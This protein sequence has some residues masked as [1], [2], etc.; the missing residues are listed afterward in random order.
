MKPNMIKNAQDLL[1]DMQKNFDEIK[2]LSRTQS[3]AFENFLQST[4]DSGMLDTKT[5]ALIG[6][7]LA[8]LKQCKWCITYYVKTALDNKATKEQILEAGWLAVVMGGFS[9]YT[10]LQILKKSMEDLLQNTQ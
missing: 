8:V 5:K 4:T 10:Y 7:A 3:E 9:A 6:V 1:N 2:G